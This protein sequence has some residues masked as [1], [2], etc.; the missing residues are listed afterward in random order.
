MGKYKQ[1][2]QDK[3]AKIVALHNAGLQ[4]KDILQQLGVCERSVRKYVARFHQGGGKDT[5]LK[6]Q[7]LVALVRLHNVL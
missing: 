4:T 7:G 3:L 1:L 5:P 6:N 2:S